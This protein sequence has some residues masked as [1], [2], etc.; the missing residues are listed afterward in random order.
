MVRNKN[1]FIYIYNWSSPFLIKSRIP[2][3]SLNLNHIYFPPK[4][5]HSN[6]N[7]QNNLIIL[8]L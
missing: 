3:I 5:I 8:K 6:N 1:I 4:N 7:C 2:E